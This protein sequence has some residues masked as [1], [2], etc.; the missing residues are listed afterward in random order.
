[1]CQMDLHNQKKYK[2]K[3]LG[4]KIYGTFYGQNVS[5]DVVFAAREEI[6]YPRV[7]LAQIPVYRH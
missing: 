6:R 2:S 5:E 1:M 4:M 3:G 7:N